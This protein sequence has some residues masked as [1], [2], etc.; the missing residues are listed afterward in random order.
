MARRYYSSTAQRT[1]ITTDITSSATSIVVAAVTGFPS[2][3]P[4]TLVLDVDTVNEEIIT[5]TNI[6][7]TTLTV[8][9]GVDGTG[10]VAH[11]SGAVVAHMVTA[12]DL[13]EPN[14]LVNLADAKGDLVAA[15]AADTWVRVA[16]GSDGQLL[17]AD[18]T[19]SSGVAWA[20]APASGF[21]SFLL[22]G[23]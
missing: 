16:V 18:S 17:T 23:A 1:T 13:D 14:V 3:R 5:V 7:G 4:Y 11:S 8:T 22:M 15:S 19:A 9:R 6:S 20:A 2:S 21:N 10:G 12:R